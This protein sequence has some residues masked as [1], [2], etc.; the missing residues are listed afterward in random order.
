M[1]MRKFLFMLLFSIVTFAVFSI[2]VDRPPD[3]DVVAIEI[4]Q[5][6]NFICQ[7]VIDNPI[8]NV[9]ESACQKGTTFEYAAIMKEA[10][11]NQME[12]KE[13]YLKKS[14]TERYLCNITS[15]N[16]NLKNT[17]IKRQSFMNNE[18]HNTGKKNCEVRIRSPEIQKGMS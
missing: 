9:L 17:A 12:P 8:L 13:I 18:S 6:T 2:P 7:V 15:D 4:T 5:Q 14:G 3:K 16:S 11:V 1:L 10:E